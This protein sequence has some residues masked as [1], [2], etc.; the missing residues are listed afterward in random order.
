M[1]GS[2][3]VV[4][5]EYVAAGGQMGHKVGTATGVVEGERSGSRSTGYR[6]KHGSGGQVAL[7]CCEQF[8]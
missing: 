5:E 7:L 1:E 4:T 3:K 8:D 6:R 2:A